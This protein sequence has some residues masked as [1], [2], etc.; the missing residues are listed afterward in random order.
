[1]VKYIKGGLFATEK[2]SESVKIVDEQCGER[3]YIIQHRSGKYM[4]EK[5][6][7]RFMTITAARRDPD[8]G[9]LSRV[10]LLRQSSHC[11]R[12]WALI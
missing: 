5:W 7:S 12:C 8:T 4:E 2:V 10:Y 1:M 3:S 11:G 6:S 9:A